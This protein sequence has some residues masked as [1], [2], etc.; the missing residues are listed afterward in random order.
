MTGR[1]DATGDSIARNALWAFT[2]QLITSAATAA[3]TLY[4]VRALGPT[5]F[6]VLALAVGIGTLMLMPGDF[7]L[8]ASA[9][10]YIAEHRG[11]WPIIAALLRDAMRLKLVVTAT[12]SIAMFALAGVVA[13]IANTPALTW[14][15]RGVA[16]GEFF[17][18]FYMLF[19]G[20]F[21]ALQRVSVNIRLVSTESLVEAGAASGLVLLGAGAA[22]AAFGRALG[23]AAAAAVGFVLVRRLVI[24]RAENVG[25][26]PGGPRRILKYGSALLVIDSA[27]ALLTPIGTLLTGAFLGPAAVGVFSA[28]ARLITFLHYP[29]YSVASGVAPRLARGPGSE[30]DTAALAGG[31]RWILLFQ[32]VLVAPTIVWARPIADIVLGSGYA[33]SAHVLALLAPYT[34]LSGFAPLVSLSVNYMGEARRRVPIA[35]G[36]VLLS[37]ALYCALVPAFELTGAAVA[38]D[39]A[40]AFYVV[41]HF[42][43]CRQLVG[44]PL[45]PVAVDLVRCVGAA[46]AMAGVMALFGTHKLG[47]AQ[48]IAGGIAGIATYLVALLITRAVT[49]GELRAARV[50][51]AGKLRRRPAIEPA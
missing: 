46:T 21:I 50:A 23:Y 9:A 34:F 48:I 45:R 32:T 37:A 28:P 27:W 25:H 36:T 22:G 38:T 41:A 43:L 13:D 20:T 19:T 40:Y 47:A 44:L 16:I 30:P 17:Q 12:I 10:R 8:S 26:F 51:V 4:L 3:L 33:E 5:G 35:I 42:W 15:L 14:P 6:G 18:S 7:G 24:A 2:A 29:G 39:L 31:L 49:L 11:N 1:S